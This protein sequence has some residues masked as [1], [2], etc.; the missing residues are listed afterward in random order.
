MFYILNTWN[1]YEWLVKRCNHSKNGVN[2]KT[3][4]YPYS[5]KLLIKWINNR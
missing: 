4:C 5:Q 2:G 3:W 1:L